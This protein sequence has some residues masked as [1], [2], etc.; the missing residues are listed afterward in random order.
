MFDSITLVCVDGLRDLTKFVNRIAERFEFRN[1]YTD[2]NPR[3][4]AGYDDFVVRE[5][6]KYIATEFALIVQYDG[7]PLKISAWNEGFLKYDYIGAPWLLQ[8]WARGK[9]VGN[10]G[11]SLRSKR[12]LEQSACLDYDSNCYPEDAFLCRIADKE[13]KGKGIRFAPIDVAYDFSVE[14]MPY[15]GQFGFHGKK[16]IEINRELKLFDDIPS[17]ADKKAWW[18]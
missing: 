7:Y 2:F 16:T 3:S 12:F 9:T 11:F 17:V 10:G 4:L 14:D 5:L 13:L 6:H 18:A 8:P 1:V 15:K